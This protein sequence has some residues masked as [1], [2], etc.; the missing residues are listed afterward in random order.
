MQ[1]TQYNMS[2]LQQFIRSLYQQRRVGADGQVQIVTPNLYCAPFGYPVTFTGLGAGQSQTTQIAITAN[3]D[4]LALG[5]K[6]HASNAAAAQTNSTK[7]I[8]CVRIQITDSGTAEQWTNAP[9][10]LENYST[11]AGDTRMLPFPRL[12]QGKTSLTVQATSYAAAES[13]TLDLFIEGVLIKVLNTA[14]MM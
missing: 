5:L 13:Y 2:E 8:P 4:F 11:N 12:V 6:H 1:T 9:V 7:T 3:G 10:D 14:G